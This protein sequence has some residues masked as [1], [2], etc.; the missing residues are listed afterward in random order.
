MQG[1]TRQ[2]TICHGRPPARQVRP[3]RAPLYHYPTAPHFTGAVGGDDYA[4]WL[5]AL[6]AGTPTSIYVHIPFCDSLCW[7]CGCHMRVVNRY[8]SIS[9]YL[10]LLRREIDLAAAAAADRP[11][12]RLH[13]GGRPGGD[14]R[15]LRR[16]YGRRPALHARRPRG[17]RPLSRPGRR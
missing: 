3:P 6:E 13:G 4:A 16:H 14:R 1:P 10:D 7:F 17:V 8:A 12:I 9:A 15:L 5:G 11:T 2:S